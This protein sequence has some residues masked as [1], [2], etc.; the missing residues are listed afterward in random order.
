MLRLPKMLQ[1]W[2]CPDLERFGSA[3]DGGY[4][5]NPRD[6][7]K[8][9]SL[10]SLGVGENCEFEKHCYGSYPMPVKAYDGTCDP[11]FPDIRDFFQDDRVLNL[12]RVSHT[13]SEFDMAFMDIWQTTTQNVFVKCDIE[14]SEYE[15]FD[16]LIVVS[17]QITGLVMEVHD[18]N[19]HDNIDR[20]MDFVTRI[21]LKL[22]HLH[23]N[24]YFYYQTESG[25][26]PDV[27]EL[28]FS[29]GNNMR[30]NR[31]LTLPH[32]LDQPNNPDN[33]EFCFSW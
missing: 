3:N 2:H 17:D 14:G 9:Q 5:V 28:T 1:P 21:N 31:S 24:N 12:Q 23:V 11:N 26:V 19:S 20:L 16:D 4:L 13:G 8:S 30:L 18:I 27:L 6:L 29:S 15:M 7:A 25:D 10:L 32:L 22:V 33:Q